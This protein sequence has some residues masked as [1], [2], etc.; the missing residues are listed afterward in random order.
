VSDLTAKEQANV[1]AA[2]SFLRARC[3]GVKLLAK[4]LRIDRK[5]LRN[6]ATPTTESVRIAVTSR[7]THRED[8]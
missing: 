3:G 4:A 6:P 2:M 1:R 7:A 8:V 5:T